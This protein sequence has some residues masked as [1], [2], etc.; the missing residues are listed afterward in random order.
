MAPSFQL[1]FYKGDTPVLVVD[2]VDMQGPLDLEDTDIKL[3]V[4]DQV[5]QA[6]INDR[7]QAAFFISK[8]ISQ[9]LK[10]GQHRA[11]IQ[12]TTTKT[13]YSFYGYIRVLRARQ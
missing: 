12:F 2:L 7:N 4:Q 11:W 8:D 1:Q 3:Y 6:V 10:H 13:K 5:V 9:K